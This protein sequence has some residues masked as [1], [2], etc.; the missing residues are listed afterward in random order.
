MRRPLPGTSQALAATSSPQSPTPPTSGFGAGVAPGDPR[1]LAVSIPRAFHESIGLLPQRADARDRSQ[2]AGSQPLSAYQSAY[3]PAPPLRRPEGMEPNSARSRQPQRVDPSRFSSAALPRSPSMPSAAVAPAAAATARAHVREA[4][5][6]RA[7]DPPKPRTMD[8]HVAKAASELLAAPGTALLAWTTAGSEAEHRR[9]RP[10]EFFNHF[11][12][13]EE[14]TTKSGLARN[15]AWHAVAS[16]ANVDRFFPRCYDM[17]QRS[18]RDDFILDFRRGAALKVALLHLRLVVDSPAL[19][20]SDPKR[21]YTCSREMI[22]VATH[23]LL[24]WCQELDP[25]HIDEEGAGVEI[26]SGRGVAACA[27]DGEAAWDSLVLYSDLTQEQLSAQEEDAE[28]TRRPR[29]RYH[30][31]GGGSIEDDAKRGTTPGGHGGGAEKPA[32]DVASARRPVERP[33]DVHLWP[34]FQGHHWLTA[35]EVD[36]SRLREVVAQL[37]K[38]FPQWNLQGGCFGRNVWIVKPGT[39]SKGSGIEC[40]DTLP[41]LLHHCDQMP[42]RLVQKYIERPLLLFS[43]RKFDI[44]Q[45]VLVR[46]VNPLRVFLF[47]ECYLRLCNGMY[48]LGDLRDRERHISNWQVNKN[49]KNVVDGAAVS[50]SDFRAELQEITGAGDYWEV[51]LLPQLRQ[52]VVQTLRAAEERLVPRADS[53]ELYGFDLMVDESMQM[54]LLEVNLSPGCEGRTPFLDRMLSRMATRLVEVAVLGR[55]EP[56]GE[57]PDWVKICDDVSGGGPHAAAAGQDWPKTADLTVHGEAM[58]GPKRPRPRQQPAQPTQQRPPPWSPPAACSSEA[59]AGAAANTCAPDSS[60][61]A[62]PPPCEDPEV[63]RETATETEQ[64]SDLLAHPLEA[65]AGGAALSD[66]EAPAAALRAAA[67]LSA[68]QSAAAHPRPEEDKPEAT[69]ATSGAKE[70]WS[71]GA[72]ALPPSPTPED[73]PEESASSKTSGSALLRHSEETQPPACS[74]GVDASAESAG[75]LERESAAKIDEGEFAR[76][77]SE[78]GDESDN[79]SEVEDS[80]EAGSEEE[81]SSDAEVRSTAEVTD[82]PLDNAGR[83]SA[84]TLTDTASHDEVAAR[85]ETEDDV[86]SSYTGSESGSP[87]HTPSAESAREAPAAVDAGGAESWEEASMPRSHC[88]SGAAAYECVDDIGASQMDAYV[89]VDAHVRAAS[90]ESAAWPVGGADTEEANGHQGSDSF[91]DFEDDHVQA[92]SGTGAAEPVDRADTKAGVSGKQGGDSSEEF[93]EEIAPSPSSAGFKATPAARVDIQASSGLL[94]SYEDDGFEEEASPL[95]RNETS[96]DDF[97][98]SFER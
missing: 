24:L 8:E 2:R 35:R 64:R 88:V 12:C 39:N 31:V 23:T 49:G 69:E 97:E 36:T 20:A 32:G 74:G 53:F 63:E 73:I 50:L 28:L 86:Q 22:L 38:V 84:E 83:S 78:N 18:E 92:V 66:A 91:E 95:D 30:R 5:L 17:G 4:S 52:I 76:P 33:A 27:R 89:D 81:Y 54:W 37:E 15:L 80:A 77:A 9:L 75:D 43:G 11:R 57:Q 79:Y 14:L 13:T 96:Q 41:E 45:W 61:E 85:R 44:R 72:A 26:H 7:R 19:V 6:R 48:D 67:E 40:M 98:A 25:D 68:A 16:G 1:C 93:E 42:N 34:E 21:G 87:S 65:N 58:L 90:G 29:R 55:E 62:L 60:V 70:T 47:S 46:S 82:K 56:D 59:V 71:L 94:D 51:S 10:G 3:Q